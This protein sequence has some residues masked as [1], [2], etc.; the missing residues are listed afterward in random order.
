MVNDEYNNVF[1]CNWHIVTELLHVVYRNIWRVSIDDKKLVSCSAEPND[2]FA[3]A[4]SRIMRY[5]VSKDEYMFRYSV[6]FNPMHVFDHNN[7][8]FYKTFL[9]TIARVVI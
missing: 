6:M 4:N 7:N 8:L 2:K 3:S 5:E 9:P 1:M